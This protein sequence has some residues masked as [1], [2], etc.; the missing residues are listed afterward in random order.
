MALRSIPPRT[1][2][3][4][5]MKSSMRASDKTGYSMR[6]GAESAIRFVASSYQSHQGSY[7][8]NA[9]PK[10]KGYTFERRREE[11][12]AMQ[13]RLSYIEDEI[14]TW[15]GEGLPVDNLLREADR[16]KEKLKTYW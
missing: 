4:N 15:A 10:G 8:I 5:G 1:R 14:R 6:G 3:G 9:A 11:R 13:E 7:P 12:R 16:L 2:I